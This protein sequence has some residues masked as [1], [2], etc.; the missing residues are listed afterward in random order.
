[1]TNV[2]LP[3]Q[4]TSFV[5]RTGDL[6]EIA[7]LLAEPACRLLTLVGPG[8]IGKTRCQITDESASVYGQS[9]PPQKGELAAW[10]DTAS[11]TV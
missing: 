7:M 6:V 3:P 1:M 11:R 9:V 5:G 8:G 4:L 2:N 10:K